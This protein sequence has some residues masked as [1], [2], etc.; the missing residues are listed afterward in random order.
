[1]YTK[2]KYGNLL[3]TAFL[4]LVCS[5]TRDYDDIPLAEIIEIPEVGSTI[6]GHTVWQANEAAGTF[7]V[8]Q[9]ASGTMK[10]TAIDAYAASQGTGWEIPDQTTLD[11]LFVKYL[12]LD[13]KNANHPFW[14][15]EVSEDGTKRG[16]VELVTGGLTIITRKDYDINESHSVVLVKNYTL[17]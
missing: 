10:G 6:E 11:N 14:T 12:R 2:T 17:K 13:E 15:S 9:V 7:S 16:T 1:M 4:L 8:V 3:L 5:C